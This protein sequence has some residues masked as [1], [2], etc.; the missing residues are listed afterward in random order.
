[1]ISPVKIWR[2]QK[3]VQK[4]IGATGEILT[5]TVIRVPMS[6]FTDQAPHPVVI[7]SLDNGTRLTAQMVDYR[8]EDIVP[9]RRVRVVLR[10]I[11]EPDTDGVIPYGVKVIPV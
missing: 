6:G 9:G 3:K 10:R 11:R 1:M 4:L 5:W 2:N 8:D 7:V